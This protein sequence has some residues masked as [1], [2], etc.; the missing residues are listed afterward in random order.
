MRPAESSMGRGR[1]RASAIILELV[2]VVLFGH[3]SADAAGARGAFFVPT[4][5][6]KS[7]FGHFSE[8]RTATAA[9]R[10]RRA[11]G[12]PSSVSSGIYG[13]RS[14]RLRWRELGVVADF[15]SYGTSPPDACRFGTFLEATL[16]DPRWHTARGIRPGSSRA[17]ARRAAKRKCTRRTVG[18]GLAFG[19]ALGLQPSNCAPG[20]FPTVIAEV[21]GGKVTALV[22]RSRSCE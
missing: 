20:R 13:E 7:G 16:S 5:A 1:V 21:G 19:F 17:A 10:M 4:G 22:V 11:L 12:Q 14:C 18:C 9:A 15:A 2:A 8:P 3:V 6:G